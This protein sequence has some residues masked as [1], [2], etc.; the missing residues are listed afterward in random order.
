MPMKG[1]MPPSQTDDW[2]TPGELFNNL[3]E[4]HGFTFDAAASQH[5]V[6][7]IR[8]RLKFGGH[9]VSAPFPS[10]IVEMSK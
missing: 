2:A 4:I 6:T 3:N 8:G 9:E 10:I 7:F 1:Y 5:K